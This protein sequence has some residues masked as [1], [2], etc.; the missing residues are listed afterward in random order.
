MIIILTYN[1]ELI[2]ILYFLVDM[3]RFVLL[4]LKTSYE[5]DHTFDEEINEEK[6]NEH[7]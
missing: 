7:D 1:D 6:K 2:S 5:D 3:I 4:L